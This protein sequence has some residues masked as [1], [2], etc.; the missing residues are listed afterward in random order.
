MTL[1]DRSYAAFLFDMDGTL[2]DSIA[3]ANRAWTRWA[4]RHG[5]DAAAVLA[6]MHGARAVDTIARLAP[7][8]SDIEGEA[9]LLTQWEV[10]DVG[11][12]VAIGGAAAF[13]RALPPERWALVTSAPRR[14]ALPRLAAAGL[15]PPAVFVTAEDV[16]R[17]KPAP[18]GFLAAA[19]ALGVPPEDC[20]VWED[21]APGIAAAEA[22]GCAVAVITATHVRRLDTP[23]RG[24][25]DYETLA[26]EVEADGRL[27][28]VERTASVLQA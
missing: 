9:A 5:L 2:I 21:S 26:V 14:L 1:A 20:L 12:V 8:G 19:H 3:S 23:S 4:A 10:E 15:T 17:G 22:A 13:L 16:A 28:L 24:F 7:A 27:R 25:G 6:Q 18:D 11:D